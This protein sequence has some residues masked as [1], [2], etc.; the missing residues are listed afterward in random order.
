MKNNSYA[1]AFDAENMISSYRMNKY[2]M[3]DN[4][5]KVPGNSLYMLRLSEMY[6][7]KAE[8]AI[9]KPAPEAASPVNVPSMVY[10]SVL[11]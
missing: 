10:P 1:W 9:R 2:Q 6:L 11:L 8:A 7:V 3:N 4:V 5:D